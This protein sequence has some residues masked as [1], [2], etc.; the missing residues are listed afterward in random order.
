M[1]QA[2][3]NVSSKKTEIKF[4]FC[5]Y[6]VAMN[7]I[8]LLTYAILSHDFAISC[9][10]NALTL[11]SFSISVPLFLLCLGALWF[12][13]YAIYSMVDYLSQAETPVLDYAPPVTILK[14]LCG[15]DDNTDA[16][17]ASF[18]EQNY[19]RYQVIFAV[20]EATDPSVEVVQKLIH[21]FPDRDIQLVI[22]NREIGA[23]PK[24]N[25]L[26]NAA[27]AAKHELW[28]IADSDIRVG[29]D[30]LQ[31]VVQ[32]LRYPGVGVV[33]CPYRSQAT[34]LVATLEA[35][36]TATEFHPGVLVARKLEGVHFAFGQTIVIRRVLLE[37][38]GGFEAIA[39]YLADDFQ[40]GNLP[41]TVGYR[42]VLSHYIVEH[43]LSSHA[44]WIS[45][46]RQMRWARGIRVSRPW[47]YLGKI[48]TY[49]TVMSLGLLGVS[50]G[51]PLGW[52]M[53][54]LTWTIRSLMAWMIGIWWL[55]D[56]PTR[57]G[58]WLL[59]LYDMI[60]FVVWCGGLMGNSI[61]WR[62]NRFRLLPGGKLQPISATVPHKYALPALEKI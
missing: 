42:V 18:C 49:G 34:G 26:A 60:S 14:P 46:Q 28:V 6:H 22:S 53:L 59:P 23:N 61:E 57:R 38:L 15:L 17:L 5:Q 31:K 20:K 19:P 30:Y 36:G 51:S 35:I 37:K 40:L 52:T 62:G 45:L 3:L 11:L 4:Q 8:A 33:T 44:F 21:Q 16:N 39:D 50:G 7:C 2:I 48:F 55:N 25:N 1:K 32:P 56:R 24:V 27:S 41:A 9:S 58:W 54:V 29:K 43:G 47:G 10:M 12:Y 13:G